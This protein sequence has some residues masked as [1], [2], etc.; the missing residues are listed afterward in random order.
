M[1]KLFLWFTLY[2]SMAT[3]DMSI[4]IRIF[5]MKGMSIVSEKPL[6]IIDTLCK[7]LM[8]VLQSKNKVMKAINIR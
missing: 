6:G 7:W 8:V 2:A 3:S 5:K 1:G 4:I